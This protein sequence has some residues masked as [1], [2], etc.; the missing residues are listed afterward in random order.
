MWILYIFTISLMF[1][2]FTSVLITTFYK[3][4]KCFKIYVYFNV[5]HFHDEMSIQ[6]RRNTKWTHFG[7][8]FTS[9]WE[10]KTKRKLILSKLLVSIK[11]K[12]EITEYNNSL[13]KKLL[14]NV[15]WKK[16]IL[17]RLIKNFNLKLDL[18]RFNSSNNQFIIHF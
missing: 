6:L 7:N 16:K 9:E 1:L 5:I 17:F 12:R 2:S 4:K 11:R 15:N 13:G 18:I 10:M 14:R 3:A 8:Y